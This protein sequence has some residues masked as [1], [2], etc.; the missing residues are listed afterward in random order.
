M[1]GLQGTGDR[2]G[3]GDMSEDDRDMTAKEKEWLKRLKQV[4]NTMPKTLEVTV[5]AG[6]SVSVHNEGATERFFQANGNADNAPELASFQAKRGLR[7][8]ESSI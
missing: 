6:G 5:R 1:G 8:E 7:G 4:I 2:E 3:D